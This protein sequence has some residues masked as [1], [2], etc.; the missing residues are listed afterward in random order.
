VETLAVILAIAYLVLAIRENRWCWPAGIGSSLLYLGVFYGAGLY[1]QAWLQ[2]FYAGMGIYGW[3][4]WRPGEGN[5]PPPAIQR[6][7]PRAHALAILAI[8]L[9]SIGSGALLARH[10]E[11]AAPYLDSAVAWSAMLTTWMVARKLLENWLY[12]FVID[13]ASLGLALQGGLYTTA[14]LFAL[15]LVLVVT[16]WRRWLAVWA[17]QRAGA[18]P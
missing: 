12:W 15:Y 2:V 5:R 9:L 8:A 6:W 14:G 11:A 16:G 10:T 4:A 1:M 18:G 3:W 13:A 7:P 17:S